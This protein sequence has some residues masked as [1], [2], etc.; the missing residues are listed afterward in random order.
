MTRAVE[1][2]QALRRHLRLLN[3][4]PV[5]VHGIPVSLKVAGVATNF[6]KERMPNAKIFYE[7]LISDLKEM[8]NRFKTIHGLA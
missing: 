8:V 1:A 6:N 7:T 4:R 3:T 2:K 5:K